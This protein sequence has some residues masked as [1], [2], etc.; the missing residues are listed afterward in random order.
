MAHGQH[1]PKRSVDQYPH[2]EDVLRFEALQMLYENSLKMKIILYGENNLSVAN[3]YGLQAQMYYMQNKYEKAE[4]LY[5]KCLAIEEKILPKNHLS[6]VETYSKLAFTCYDQNKY[7][8]ALV[9]Y[10]KVYSIFAQTFGFDNPSTSLIYEFVKIT[11]FECN[12]QGNFEQW[13]EEQMK[14]WQ[15]Q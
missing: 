7:Q 13:L 1:G 4:E 15:G 14:E 8:K 5:E 9:Y 2:I 10:F 3:S 6:I 12:P 11:Y